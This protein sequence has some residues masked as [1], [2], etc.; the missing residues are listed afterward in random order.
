[1][2]RKLVVICVSLAYAIFVLSVAWVIMTMFFAPGCVKSQV[3][4]YT[5]LR[6]P[7]CDVVELGKSLG[8]VQIEVRCPGQEPFTRKYRERS[9]R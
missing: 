6:Y 9:S 8:E 3:E 4:E 1:V 2:K 7:G 5:K